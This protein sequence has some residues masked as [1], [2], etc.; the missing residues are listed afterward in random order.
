MCSALLVRLALLLQQYQV[1]VLIYRWHSIRKGRRQVSKATT[2]T[3]TTSTTT[4]ELAPLYSKQRQRSTRQA[5]YSKGATLRRRWCPIYSL[6][7]W[8]F[9]AQ[10]QYCSYG[11]QLHCWHQR[12]PRM[13]EAYYERTNVNKIWTKM[14]WDNAKKEM[15]RHKI[16]SWR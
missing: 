5:I 3:T 9:D 12:P 10:V 7:D 15:L 11:Y 16:L 6:M 1:V 13:S 8:Q 14:E 2:T 4:E